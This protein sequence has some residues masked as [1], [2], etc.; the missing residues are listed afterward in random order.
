M[1]AARKVT[2]IQ[3]DI[4]KRFKEQVASPG[5]E[6]AWHPTF[7]PDGPTQ[8]GGWLYYGYSENWGHAPPAKPH[9]MARRRMEIVRG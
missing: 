4:D 9:S 7:V 1:L 3:R 6:V 5:S 8:A 2:E